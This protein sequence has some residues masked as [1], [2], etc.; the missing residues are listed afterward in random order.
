MS[1]EEA[2]T[3]GLQKPLENNAQAAEDVKNMLAELKAE[4]QTT[5]ASSS[6]QTTPAVKEGTE[7]KQLKDSGEGAAPAEDIKPTK[8]VAKGGPDGRGARDSNGA[9]RGQRSRA[10]KS[11]MISDLESQD[12]TDDPVAIRKQVSVHSVLQA[13]KMLT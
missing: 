4:S 8:D 13:S 12:V 11:R 7:E 3:Q 1:V 2:V 9:D 5:Q 6:K 10:T